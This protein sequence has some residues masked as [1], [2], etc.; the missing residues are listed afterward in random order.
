MRPSKNIKIRTLKKHNP[1][2]FLIENIELLGSDEKIGFERTDEY[3]EINL[4]GELRNDLPIC[5]KMEIG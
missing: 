3:L 1:H 4:K 2:D 5:F